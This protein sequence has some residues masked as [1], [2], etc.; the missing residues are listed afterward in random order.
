MLYILYGEDD[1]S[2]RQALAVIKEEMG[3]KELLSTNTTVLQGQNLTLQQLIMT[4]DTLPF[5]APK[6]LVM[7][8]G[9]LSRFEPQDKEKHSL[10]PKDSEWQSFREYVSRMSESTVLILVDGE[11]KRN[12]P[13]LVELAPLAKVREFKS[14]KGDRLRDWMQSRA[15]NLECNISPP[16]LKLLSELVG[17]NLGL[18]SIEIDKLCLYAHGRRVEEHDVKSLVAYAQETNVFNMVDAI[19]ERNAPKATRLLHLLE[20][21][22]AAP[23]YLLFMITRQLRMVIQAKDILQQKHASAD[24]GHSLGITSDYVLQKV[25]VQ[26]GTHSMEQLTAIYQKLLD[27]DI[28]IKTGKIKGD[29]G[30]LALDLLV[31]ELCEERP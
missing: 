6:R 2:L 26:A 12:N 5:L 16:A 1:F 14:L 7:V 20:D 24:M 3:D 15:K 27:T 28:S 31:C 9:L 19:L 10:K 18:L 4:C 30:E 23:P 29:R 21:E 17:S 25:R 8:E 22:G 11:L 13:M